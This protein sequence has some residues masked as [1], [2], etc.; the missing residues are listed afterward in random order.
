[1][2]LAALGDL[3]RATSPQVLFRMKRSVLVFAAQTLTA[4]L[5]LRIFVFAA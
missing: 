1:M 3:L 5:S 4:V 2:R